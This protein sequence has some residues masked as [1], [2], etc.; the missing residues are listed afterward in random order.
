VLMEMTLRN[1]TSG[2]GVDHPDD[3]LAR[4][5][6]LG[7]LGFDVLISR[8][9]QYYR[10]VDY[11]ATYTEAPIG[12]AVGLPSVTEIVNERYYENLAGGMLESIGLL[13][14]RS[15]RMYVYPLRD[16]ATGRVVT[17]ETLPVKEAW[18]H[19]R[20]FLLESRHLVPIHRYDERLLTIST[21]DVLARIRSADPAWEAMV[22]P[23]VAETIKARR[24][25]GNHS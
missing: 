18:R 12:I 13:F 14:K 24:L 7:V 25:F 6:T 17:V 20:D 22:P 1:L 8:F 2:A 16:A 4:A 10:L 15:V 19:L 9:T 23:A 21:E 3:F 11:L 5:D